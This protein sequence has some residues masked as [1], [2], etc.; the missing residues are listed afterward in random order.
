MNNLNEEDVFNFLKQPKQ[1]EGKFIWTQE[2]IPT[3]TIKKIPRVI[4]ELNIAYN[5]YIYEKTEC[6]VKLS[7]RPLIYKNDKPQYKYSFILFFKNNRILA[8]D[9]D[10]STRHTNNIGKMYY[11]DEIYGNH[12]HYWIHDHEVNLSGLY[13]VPFKDFSDHEIKENFEFFCNKANLTYNNI[14]FI[15]PKP[16]KNDGDVE[17]EGFDL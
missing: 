8:L 15:K 2:K 16:W 12:I 5:N 13:A 14:N 4:C 9:I 3:G 17:Q 7:W 10:P 1:L 6:Y 11:S